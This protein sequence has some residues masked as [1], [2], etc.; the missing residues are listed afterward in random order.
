MICRIHWGMETPFP[1]ILVIYIGFDIDHRAA[2]DGI[3]AG[4]LQDIVFSFVQPYD[5][6]QDR[7]GTGRAEGAEKAHHRNLLAAHGMDPP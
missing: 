5:A 4:D 6:G 2:V 1:G 7:I 3:Q